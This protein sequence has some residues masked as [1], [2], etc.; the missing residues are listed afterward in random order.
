MDDR[1]SGLDF[2]DSIVLNIG[3]TG[4]G[5]HLDIPDAL[6]PWLLLNLPLNTQKTAREI[7]ACGL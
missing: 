3:Y 4:F 2:Y 6:E 7:A 1:V 5:K